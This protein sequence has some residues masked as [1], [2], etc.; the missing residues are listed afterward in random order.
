MTRYDTDFH[1]WAMEQAEALQR[2][3]ANELD[4]DNL[5]EELAT[6]GRSEK[7]ELNARYIVLLS[8]LLKWIFQPERRS[9]SWSATI[10]EQRRAISRHLQENP[11]LKAADAQE[12]AHAYETA[13]LRASGETDLSM[14][15]FPEQPP[16]T[17]EQAKAE[18]W[19]PGEDEA[20]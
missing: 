11:S 19:W 5:A 13:R 1:A 9:R 7:G 16:F 15:A 4:W 12:F 6:L 2:R 8:H 14:E 10:T 17:P 20:A 3:S 18:D